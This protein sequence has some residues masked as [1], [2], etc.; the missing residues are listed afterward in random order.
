MSAAYHT[1]GQA[2]SGTRRLLTQA[3][4]PPQSPLSK[5]GT[6]EKARSGSSQPAAVHL[7]LPKFTAARRRQPQFTVAF[8]VMVRRYR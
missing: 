1:G 6:E 8:G 5:G 7:S 4:N 3:G 2:A